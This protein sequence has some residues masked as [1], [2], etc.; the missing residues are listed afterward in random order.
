MLSSQAPGAQFLK[1]FIPQK[2]PLQGP[3]IQRGSLRAGGMQSRHVG[4]MYVRA[5]GQPS[6]TCP[7][8]TLDTIPTSTTLGLQRASVHTR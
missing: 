2:S 4:F 3:H 5:P 6:A 7:P 8:T 1:E